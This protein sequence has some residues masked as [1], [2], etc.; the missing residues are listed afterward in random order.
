[1]ASPTAH[2]QGLLTERARLQDELRRLRDQSQ[3]DT[4]RTAAALEQRSEALAKQAADLASL[5]EALTKSDA[6]LRAAQL[7]L[8]LRSRQAAHEEGL[9]RDSLRQQEAALVGTE[10]EGG[11]R[12]KR[13]RMQSFTRCVCNPTEPASFAR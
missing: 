12:G 9:T 5:R 3:A 10:W 6:E 7:E 13:L 11:G 2:T 1:L 8:Q 4:V